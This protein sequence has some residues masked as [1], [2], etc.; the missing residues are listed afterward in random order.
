[1]EWLLLVIGCWLMG[2]A[3]CLSGKN[4]ISKLIF[5]VVPFFM[6]LFLI[7]YFLVVKGFVVI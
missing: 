4:G 2:W 3:V 1:M 7:F 5:N 6:G